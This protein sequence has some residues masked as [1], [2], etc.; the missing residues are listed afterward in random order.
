MIFTLKH[1]VIATNE[2]FHL[3]FCSLLLF[4]KKQLMNFDPMKC[5]CLPISKDLISNF[6]VSTSLS[7]LFGLILLSYVFVSLQM[8][9][10]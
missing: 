5:F 1:F 4:W 2:S 6:R 3:I 7:F 8:R 10:D 9:Q